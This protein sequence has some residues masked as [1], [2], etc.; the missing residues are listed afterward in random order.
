[1]LKDNIIQKTE[2]TVLTFTDSSWNDCDDTGMSTGGYI[3][4]RQ[5]GAV[6]YGSHLPVPVAM[7]SSAAEYI[8][9]GGWGKDKEI[10]LTHRS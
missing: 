8:S 5:A 3:I 6:D 9:A 4:L 10:P 7:S 1:M 2:E